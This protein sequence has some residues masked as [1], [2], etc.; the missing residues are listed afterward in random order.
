M[1][2]FLAKICSFFL[3]LIV[4]SLF[5]P[6]SLYASGSS[7]SITVINLVRSNAQGHEKD[8]LFNSLQAQWEITD[9]AHIPATWLV[10]YSVLENNKMV[11][12][13][14]TNM[15]GQEFGLLFEIDKNFAEKSG[16][17]YKNQ[18]GPWY[19]SDSLLL[20]SYDISERRKMI[21]T[22]FA[23]FRDIFGY[24]PKTVGAWWIGA[25]SLTYMHQRYG[26][27]AALRAA[28]QYKLDEYTIWGGPWDIPYVASTTNEGMPAKS[29]QDSSGVV[30]LQWGVRDALLGYSDQLYGVQ[31][32]PNRG[33]DSGYVNFMAS[34][35]LKAPFG[36]LVFG[37]ENGGD[38][39]VFSGYYQLMLTKAQEIHSAQHVALSFAGDFA[40]KFLQQGNVLGGASVVLTKGYRSSDQAVWVN[41]EKYRVFIQKIGNKVSLIDVRNYAQKNEE[42]F[43]VLP[44]VN[45][46]LLIQEPALI[47]SKQ[48]SGQERL[49]CNCNEDLHL[50]KKG[51]VLELFSGKTKIAEFTDDGFRITVGKMQQFVFNKQFQL[52]IPLAL[53]LLYA[54]YFL[55]LL[56]R[57]S[58]KKALLEML[59]LVVPLLFALSYLKDRSFFLFDT[60]ELP[61]FSLAPILRFLTVPNLDPRPSGRGME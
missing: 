6:S 34:V 49:L 47:D 39:A 46:M 30:I 29:V 56:K 42:D 31:D 28:D 1:K 23:K 37:L 22:A 3:F 16:V 44:N 59:V 12:F 8:N 58:F 35:F 53:F 32:F 51:S 26:V 7:S 27:I 17:T 2:T 14:K 55:I 41:K 13:M 24:Y 19:F 52:S 45:P 18:G 5:V 15:H 61:L 43:A 48:V 25:D 50:S 9:D 33:Y 54:V 38:L 57:S 21:D 11:N 10:Q 20:P 60:K 36:N 4:F 40:K